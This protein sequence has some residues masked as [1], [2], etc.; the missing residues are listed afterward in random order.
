MITE[1]LATADY[2][3]S[4]KKKRKAFSRQRVL[5]AEHLKKIIEE[6]NKP[7]A[8]GTIK[9]VKTLSS[10]M[11]VSVSLINEG[12]RLLRKYNAKID[13]VRK[14]DYYKATVR[15]LIKTNPDLFNKK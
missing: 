14:D 6:Y 5:T 8:D 1:E 7:G 12:I 11:G 2:A 15:S 4:S 10:E 9:T 13:L 3:N